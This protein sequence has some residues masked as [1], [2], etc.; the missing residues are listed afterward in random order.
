MVSYPMNEFR[1]G[2]ARHRLL[3]NV[4]YH[5]SGSSMSV[6]EANRLMEQVRAYRA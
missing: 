4:I 1:D 6:D 2:L 5:V 3:P